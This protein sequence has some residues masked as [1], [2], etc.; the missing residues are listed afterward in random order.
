[1]KLLTSI[2]L[3]LSFLTATSVFASPLTYGELFY[4]KN[5]PTNKSRTLVQLGTN[6][7][8]N[9]VNVY[10]LNIE[11]RLYN[12]K[13]L[14]LWAS[15]IARST[16]LT[17]TANQINQASNV[18]QITNEPGFALYLNTK[19]ELVRAQ[20]SLL[21]KAFNEISFAVEGGYGLVKY[22]SPNTFNKEQV[23][24][25]ALG[26]QAEILLTKYNLVLGYRRYIDNVGTDTSFGHNELRV[27]LG[28]SW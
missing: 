3:I 25:L 24:S 4:V 11:Q 16:K 27:G 20:T 8:N 13:I 26:L 1:M 19:T 15:A 9:L 21:N 10:S 7:D 28:F 17:D 18:T 6:T 23:G 22:D 2:L 5:A 14:S 12:Y